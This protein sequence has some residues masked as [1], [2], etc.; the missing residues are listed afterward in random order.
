MHILILEDD[1]GV[2]GLYANALQGDGHRVSVCASFEEGR[3]ALR[4]VVPDAL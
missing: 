1:P 2:S 3:K 4:Q